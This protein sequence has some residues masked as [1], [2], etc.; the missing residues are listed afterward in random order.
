MTSQWPT[1]KKIIASYN[2]S[3]TLIWPNEKGNI[4]SANTGVLLQ[5]KQGEVIAH[6]R[7]AA[8]ILNLKLEELCRAQSI[9]DLWKTQDYPLPFENT[10]FIKTV[11]TGRS[12]SEILIIQFQN[13]EQRRLLFNSQ[14]LFHIRETEPFS[15]VTYI[16]DLT[17]SE[18]PHKMTEE[19]TKDFSETLIEAQERERTRIGHELHDNINQIL[20]VIKLFLNM[21]TPENENEKKI[22][23]KS[24]EYIFIA[25]EEIRKLSQELVVPQLI[26]KS[27]TGSI[28]RL[29]DDLSISSDIKIKFT[30]SDE[31]ELLSPGKKIT[32]FRIIQEQLKNILQYSK[33]QHIEISLQYKGNLA[34]LIIKD[35]GVGFDA[36]Q[37]RKGIGLSNIYERSRFYNGTVEVQT[38]PGE[39][40]TLIVSIPV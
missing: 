22:V 26:E 34:E 4:F 36:T 33:A 17:E 29:V 31:N 14:P 21:L 5:D 13:G 30:H 18:L 27:L 2:D 23:T 28:Q 38:K 3:A 32:I 19:V 7:V 10:C 8:E 6:N 15:V 16:V 25:I 1:I 12:H 11:K 39:G 20:S 40:C 9:R 24:R 35:D 37:T